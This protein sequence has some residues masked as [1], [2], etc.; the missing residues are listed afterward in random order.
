MSA[1]LNKVKGMIR[2][3]AATSNAGKLRDFAVA[4]KHSGIT[5]EPLPGMREIAAPAEDEPTFEDNARAKA[6]YYSR[7]APGELVMADD[8]GLE[9]DAFNGE[10]GVR[11]ARF[12]EDAGFRA[13]GT[14][15]PDERNNLYLLSRMLSVPAGKRNARYRCVLVV[16][17]D[18]DCLFTGEGM[19]EGEILDHARGQGGFGYD[20]L[21]YVPALG[22]TMAQIDLETKYRISHRGEALRALLQ[23]MRAGSLTVAAL[24]TNNKG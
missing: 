11:S 12:A 19:V 10:P 9:V 21:F 6:L 4:A 7:F 3:Y 17:R 24:K 15:A 1:E 2:I 18:G 22:K 5:I 16:A 8:S 14:P 23:A 20:P 13:D